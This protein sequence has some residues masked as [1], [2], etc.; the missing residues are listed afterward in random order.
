MKFSIRFAMNHLTAHSQT[1]H[2]IM[3][4]EVHYQILFHSYLYQPWGKKQ[5]W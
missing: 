2:W 4:A 5:K 1:Y 3:P